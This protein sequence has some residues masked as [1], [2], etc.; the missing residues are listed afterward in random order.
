MNCNVP[1]DIVFSFQGF[2]VRGGRKGPHADGWGIA[3]FGSR[4]CQLFHDLKPSAS[5][6][7]AELIRTYPLKSTNVISHIRRAN[8]GRVCVENTHPFQRELWGRS[9]VFAHNGSLAG[10]KS[11]PLR[12]Y[13]P[14]GTTDSEYAFCLI[15]DAIRARFREPPD[16]YD[17]VASVIARMAG[18]IDA[19]GTFNFLL[20]DARRL[21]AY[22]STRLCYI[23]RQAPFHRASLIDEDMEVDFSRVTTK[24][25]RVTVVATRALTGD[26]T[27]T[28]M[29]KHQLC[30]FEAGKL[31]RCLSTER[32]LHKAAG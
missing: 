14:I 13:Q 31:A 25:D 24:Q 29:P 1:T 16:D 15:L 22:C 2:R 27:W 5:S 10:L 11:M 23:T 26:E 8:R 7:V 17:K 32:Y 6:P 30:V 12:H 20:C 9:W 19:Y 18:R 3:F 21:Y 28:C 4:G